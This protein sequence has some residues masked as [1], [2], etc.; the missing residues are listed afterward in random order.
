MPSAPL[1]EMTLLAAGAV[2]PM[3]LKPSTLL[4]PAARALG[5]ATVPVASV[6]M[7]LP[8]IVAYQAP[9]RHTP[10]PPLP[11]M[12]LPEPVAVPPTVL[13]PVAPLEPVWSPRYTP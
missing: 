2:P 4:G 1:P 3:V 9:S 7:E 13:E 10:S 11:E 8:W 5:R 12:T 6:P